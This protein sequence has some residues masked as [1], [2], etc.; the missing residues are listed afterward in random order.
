MIRL[1]RLPNARGVALIQRSD[2]H[3]DVIRERFKT[4]EAMSGRLTKLYKRMGVCHAIDGMR[5]AEAISCDIRRLLEHE[6]FESLRRGEL[7]RTN[8]KCR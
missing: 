6:I 8:G 2:D 4:Y 5:A 7:Q 1:R 3:E